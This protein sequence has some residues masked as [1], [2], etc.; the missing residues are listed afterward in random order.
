MA[1]LLSRAAIWAASRI[2]TQTT[3]SGAFSRVDQNDRAANAG[4]VPE[5]KL[6]VEL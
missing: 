1:N 6:P 3:G 4:R 2:A 5:D